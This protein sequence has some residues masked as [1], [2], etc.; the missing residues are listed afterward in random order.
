MLSRQ[1][2]KPRSLS[3]HSA[4]RARGAVLVVAL[5]TILLA[6]PSSP[7]SAHY[8]CTL[9]A[10]HTSV[11]TP[12][13]WRAFGRISC[14][15]THYLYLGQVKLQFKDYQGWHTVADSGDVTGCCNNSEF[16]FQSPSWQPFPLKPRDDTLGKPKRHPLPR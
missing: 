5:M 7:A 12:A 16:Y 15:H 10:G 2:N 13:Q 8:S 9:A 6:L 3:R 11:G 1:A 14:D 4:L